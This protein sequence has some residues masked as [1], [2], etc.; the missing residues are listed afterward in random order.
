MND[1]QVSRRVEEIERGLVHDDPAFVQRLSALQRAET[2]TIV[3]VFLLLA[4]SVVLLTIGLATL[5]LPAWVAGC[6]A[7][8]MS[9]TVDEH[10]KRR[11]DL[12]LWIGRPLEG[13]TYL[14]R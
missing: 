7:F 8:V 6:L 5:S 12:N 14:P 11:Y 1:D 9:V 13:A 2:G 4:G 3:T 10:H